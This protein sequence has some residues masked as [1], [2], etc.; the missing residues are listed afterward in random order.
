MIAFDCGR[1]RP[2]GRRIT[3]TCPEGFI[4]MNESDRVPPS[5][6]LISTQS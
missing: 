3:G 2:S 1:M 6:T 4:C 5:T